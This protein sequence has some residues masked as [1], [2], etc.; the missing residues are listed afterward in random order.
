M[1]FNQFKLDRSALQTRSIFDKYIYETT[2]SIYDVSQAG[3]F[4]EARFSSDNGWNGGLIECSCSDGVFI[5]VIDAATGTAAPSIEQKPKSQVIVRS[6]D[7]LSGTL[8]SSKI[9]VID[10]IIDMGAQSIEVPA[11]G[12]SLIGYTFDVSQLISSEPNYTMFTSPIGGSGG[13]LGQNYAVTASGASSKVYDLTA[14][15]GF[16]AFE[17]LRI[18]YNDCTSLGEITN[19]R[20]GLEDGT[21]RFGGMPELTL[22]GAW[23]GGYRITTSIVRGMDPSFAGP[24]FK[25]G[26]AFTMQSRFLTDMNADLGTSASIF[27]F[28]AANFPNES[29]IQVD[30]ALISRNGV[31]DAD[32]ATTT[33]NISAD[34]LPCFW[35]NNIGL[36]NTYVGGQSAVT[37]E[38]ATVVSV[39]GTFYDVAGTTVASSLEHYDQPANGQLRHL[40]GNPRDFNLFIDYVIEGPQNNQVEMK[41]V[42]WDD[43]AAG[44]VDVESSVRQ[45][46]QLAGS[47]DVATFN[48]ISTASLDVNDYI[49]IQIANNS[50]T[51]NLTAELDSK[52]NVGER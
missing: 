28:S 38:A 45:I 31:F 34:Q 18:N 39:I 48:F 43:S 15:T 1:A 24:L 44:F 47:R 37:V 51:G 32:D 17:F 8:D 14:L 33:P 2:D 40:G 5:G 10:G 30:G 49:K 35:K 29:T 4:A 9:Y 46:N 21:G 7:D 42:K 16:E 36:D 13:L 3:Y 22:T 12:L 20:Q 19:Y 50:G 23:A 27:D 26:A 6:K 41:I 25:A 52:F 11:G